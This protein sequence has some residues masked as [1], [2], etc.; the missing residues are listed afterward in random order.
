MEDTNQIINEAFNT[1]INKHRAE[2]VL[3][4][5]ASSTGIEQT[6]ECTPSAKFRCPFSQYGSGETINC[7]SVKA[8]RL[9]DSSSN[10]LPSNNTVLHIWNNWGKTKK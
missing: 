8:F 3:Q 2:A 6:W 10:L 1:S 7:M 5:G 9:H 4:Y